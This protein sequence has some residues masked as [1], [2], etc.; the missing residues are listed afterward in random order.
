MDQKF[1][2]YLTI[3]NDAALINSSILISI[4]EIQPINLSKLA[5]GAK[6]ELI[7]QYRY[8]LR[9][10]L[11][12]IQI[13]LRF[14]NIDAPKFLH[15]K[16][17]ARTEHEIKSLADTKN[18]IAEAEEFKTWLKYYLEQNI[19]PNLVC[20]LVIP[21]SASNNLLKNET[22]YTE[23]L[24]LLS[25]RTDD[26]I[27]R[28]SSIN[29]KQELKP[30]KTKHPWETTVLADIQEKKA[31]LGLRLYKQGTKVY[32]LDSLQP[33]PNAKAR[34]KDYIKKHTFDELVSVKQQHL[35]LKRLNDAQI[36][37]LFESYQK[38]TIALFRGDGWNYLSITELFTLWL[39]GAK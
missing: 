34:I 27:T 21:V 18:I 33:V 6:T 38:D 5:G 9:S 7:H 10:L 32:S 24:Q 11:Y 35:V 26:C 39:G 12:P 23:A 19:R 29:V 16:H 37:N 17:M 22:A 4:I 8:F 3:N 31:M 14:V 25:K 28:L 13:V 20:Y 1:M 2:Q 15:R 36:K 30:V